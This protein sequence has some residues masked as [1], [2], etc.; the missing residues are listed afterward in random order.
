MVSAHKTPYLYAVLFAY[1]HIIRLSLR[2]SRQRQTTLLHLLYKRVV[3]ILPYLFLQYFAC[4]VFGNNKVRY[5]ACAQ[6]AKH[7]FAACRKAYGNNFGQLPR[8]FSGTRTAK[9]PAPLINSPRT[10]K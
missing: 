2:I 3:F 6:C 10:L 1:L 5:K 4:Y 9:S 7:G 8:V